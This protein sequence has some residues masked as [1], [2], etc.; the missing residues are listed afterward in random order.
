MCIYVSATCLQCL[1]RTEGDVQSPWSWSYRRLRATMQ[2][3]RI[4]LPSSARG[5]A[6][7]NLS[8]LRDPYF[9]FYI[10]SFVCV[11]QHMHVG[12]RGQ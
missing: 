6:A 11:C 8:H 5:A 10:Y 1:W 2:V 3:L 7:L 9:V 4:E 12:V